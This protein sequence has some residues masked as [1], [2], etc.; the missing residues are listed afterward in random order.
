[1][2]LEVGEETATK[3]CI[4]L[5]KKSAPRPEWFLI[6]TQTGSAL[7]LNQ[8]MIF[9]GR[10]KCD[11][12]LDSV[13]VDN[14]HA[15]ICFNPKDG[16]VYLRDLNT[17]HGSFVN[18]NKL[19]GP[20]YV[21]IQLNDKLR[22]GLSSQTFV[23]SNGAHIPKENI[24]DAVDMP[25]SADAPNSQ[26]CDS[27][28]FQPSKIGSQLGQDEQNLASVLTEKCSPPADQL[29]H[30][31]PACCHNGDSSSILHQTAS[32]LHPSCK[33]TS[34][35]ANNKN[36]TLTQNGVKKHNPDQQ[37]DGSILSSPIETNPPAA[38]D[39]E[40]ANKHHPAAFT[41]SFDDDDN[42]N[43]AKKK[44]LAIGDS[45]R[46]FA[47]R[48]VF[49]RHRPN[50][51]P[52]ST[53]S[54]QSPTET[55]EPRSLPI[56]SSDATG[57]AG[58][59]AQLSDSAVF[60][61]QRMFASDQQANKVPDDED[62]K[63]E[64]GTYTLEAESQNVDLERARKMIDNVF[65]V[66]DYVGAHPPG[67]PIPA[68]SS[69]CQKV[70]AS[71]TKDIHRPQISSQEADEDRCRTFTRNKPRRGSLQDQVP[72]H[73]PDS[74]A[75]NAFERSQSLRSKASDGPR[76][77]IPNPR[78][79]AERRD[80]FSSSKSGISS[81]TIEVKNAAIINHVRGGAA[82][83]LSP[84]LQRRQ[85]DGRTNDMNFAESLSSGSG[86][87]GHAAA[88]AMSSGLKL[89]RAF[90]LRRARL[91]I[92]T[93]GVSLTMTDE[94]Q[95][96]NQ[97]NRNRSNL[98]TDSSLS[99]S[100]GGRFSLRVSKG[101]PPLPTS[102]YPSSPEKR[103]QDLR[104]QVQLN[105]SRIVRAGSESN[106][107]CLSPASSSSSIPNQFVQ[108]SSS[109]GPQSSGRSAQ[110]KPDAAA[111]RSVRSMTPIQMSR[112]M[113][114]ARP[115]QQQHQD[116]GRN[117][118]Q[119]NVA[120][121]KRQPETSMMSNP[122]TTSLNDHMLDPQSLLSHQPVIQRRT[123]SSLDN[124][125]VS[126][127]LQLSGKLRFGMREWLEQEKVKHSPGSETRL[128]IDEILPQV[129]S[130][131]SC[132]P[133]QAAASSENLSKDLSTILKN[134]K[135]VEQSLEGKPLQT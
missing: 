72:S 111:D 37:S 5:R 92:E 16:C 6:N 104:K 53:H 133:E 96:K 123:L 60:L 124:L 19:P 87:A 100:D 130:T 121:I 75:D 48:K 84:R 129:S 128:M 80:S 3:K 78:I 38:C 32:E 28:I 109:F 2:S 39:S 126:A 1:M 65:G 94:K 73:S 23:V 9:V 122:M 85:S 29:Q 12:L 57:T 17:T 61:I 106:Q 44:T 7:S 46:K 59:P 93:P 64:A 13:S 115:H 113:F 79:Q 134:L 26:S 35:S 25:I 98:R 118:Q 108:R 52:P 21:K 50:S 45:I 102:S 62:V 27:S 88:N 99:R 89:N 77:P 97:D 31:P 49:E 41:I 14:R 22:F 51:K 66:E 20:S 83:S 91:G 10:A 131:S 11:V 58:P 15:V 119:A 125:V 101:R 55:N 114:S 63:S 74:D 71:L 24:N 107:A 120:P 33:K 36:S 103:S 132:H 90:A 105:S 56:M 110:R 40:S 47:P 4:D 34:Q 67:S 117:R 42:M 86:S 116:N 54:N 43:D 112:R 95:K 68:R 82:G 30:Q 8:E 18:D 76:R 135:K 70:R 81:K 127:I 69:S